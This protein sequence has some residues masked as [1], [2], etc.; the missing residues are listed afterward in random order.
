MSNATQAQ[1]ER[2]AAAAAAFLASLSEEQRDFAAMP[3]DS[4]ERERWFYTPTTR[5]GLPLRMMGA[6]QHRLAHMVV[7]SGLSLGAYNTASQIMGLENTLD[8][9]EGFRG[10][11]YHGWPSPSRNR[12]P[13][14]Y[15]LAIYGSP[16]DETWGWQ[17]G[18]HHISLNFTISGGAVV[19]PT[20]TF[21]GA[22]PAE[23]A[24]VGPSSLRPLAAEEDLARE[25]LHALS[26]EQ[27]SHALLS[28]HA[29]ADL[30]QANRSTI[31]DGALPLPLGSIFSAPIEGP[32]GAAMNG[33]VTELEA[34][35]TDADREAWRYSETPKGLAAASF[36]VP[37]NEI[38]AALVRQ[39]ICRLPDDA[40]EAE[41]SDFAATGFAGLHFAWAG[42]TERRDPHY[43][44][45]QGPRFLVE[46]DNVQNGANH[47]H[48]VWRD[49]RNDFGRDILRQHHALAH[50]R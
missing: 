11:E 34:G 45:L 32:R 30:V 31:E 13:L 28:P 29:P 50:A 43:Y 4:P 36:S 3:F 40:A 49:P 8:S 38:L 15:F 37:Q 20:P 42:G 6:D 9:R 19:S 10:W 27:R 48:T 12:D 17:F 14:M 24:G 23:S 21:F 41:W 2:M 18:G 5:A 35:A 1:A 47:V 22:D 44:R 33:M 39:Y 26:A 16:G 46:Y 7:A 25:L